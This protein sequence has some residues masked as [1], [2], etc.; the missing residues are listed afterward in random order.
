MF[1]TKTRYRIQ[2]LALASILCLA[3]CSHDSNVIYR[4]TSPDDSAEVQL[5][6]YTRFPLQ[7]SEVAELEPSSNG[8]KKVVKTWL[9][10]SFDM[11]PSFI[12]AAWS[13]DSSKVIVLYRNCFGQREIVAFAVRSYGAIDIAD[14]VPLLSS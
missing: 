11:A 14:I 2:I 9:A 4:A 8:R 13:Q 7:P 1:Y 5:S 6:T 12:A 3:N 10:K